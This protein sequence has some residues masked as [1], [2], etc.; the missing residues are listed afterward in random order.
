M[1]SD[2]EIREAFRQRAVVLHPDSGGD[3]KEFAR[4]KEAQDVLMSP[5]RRLKEWMLVRGGDVDARGQIAGGLMDL[6]QKVSEAGAAAEALIK[7]NAVAGSALVKA[8]I[9]VRLMRQ[10]EQVKDLL[11]KVAAEVELRVAQFPAVEAGECD[12]A[13]MMRDLVFLEKWRAT[14]RGIYGRLM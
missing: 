6:F 7:E 1:V 3:E 5:A 14:L 13:V 2:E 8:M 10:R 12:P 4:L 11:E 9:E